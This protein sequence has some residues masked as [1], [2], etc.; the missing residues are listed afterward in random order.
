MLVDHPRQHAHRNYSDI[1]RI[2]DQAKGLT[3]RQQQLARQMFHVVAQAEAAVHGSTIEQVQMRS[4]DEVV[5]PMKRKANWQSIIQL[6]FVA[7]SL[8]FAFI[9]FMQWYYSRQQ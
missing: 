4:G 3:D 6:L 8:F 9:Q 2:L 1:C 5:V 7:S